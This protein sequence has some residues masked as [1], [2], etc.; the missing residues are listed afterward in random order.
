V[1]EGWECHDGWSCVLIPIVLHFE[2][3]FGRGECVGEVCGGDRN[4]L[5]N[6]RVRLY[7]L[8]EEGVSAGTLEHWN[9]DCLIWRGGL[10]TTTSNSSGK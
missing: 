3:V 10:D 2:E 5:G 4:W 7:V 6:K 1:E 8:C 9:F